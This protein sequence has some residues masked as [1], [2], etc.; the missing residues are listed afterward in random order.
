MIC[1]RRQFAADDV[2]ADADNQPALVQAEGADRAMMRS[3]QVSR[4]LQKGVA[5]RRQPYQPRR[6][7]QELAAKPVF[8]PPDL[9]AD[10]GLRRVH[11]LGRPGETPGLG[12]RQES[13]KQDGI[14]H[15]PIIMISD[16][17]NSCVR[18]SQ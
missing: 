6:S 5:V 1:Q 3:D 16:Y 15:G 17:N 4:R 10:G 9:Q 7:F 2:M 11:G 18:H 8:Q 13:L 12:D 14:Q